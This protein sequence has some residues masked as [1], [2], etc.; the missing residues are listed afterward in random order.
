MASVTC[1][2]LLRRSFPQCVRELFTGSEVQLLVDVPEVG[3]DGSHR[4]KLGLGDL[5]VR[6]PPRRHFGDSALARGQGAWA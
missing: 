2:Y 5:A 4:H 3:F 1:T 6:H